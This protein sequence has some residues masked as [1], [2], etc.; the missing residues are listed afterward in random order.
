[1]YLPENN[2]QLYEILSTLRLYAAA[3]ALPSLA[4]S[5]DDA[6]HL[7]VTEAS[8]RRADARPHTFGLDKA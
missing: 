7:L 1:M 6:L 8:P 5:L 3:N 4:E 2:A